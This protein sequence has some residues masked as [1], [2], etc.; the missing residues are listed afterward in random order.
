M[1]K[2]NYYKTDFIDWNSIVLFIKNKNDNN[3]IEI[4]SNNQRWNWNNWFFLDQNEFD[5]ES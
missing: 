4:Y 5:C 1:I 2:S 3:N